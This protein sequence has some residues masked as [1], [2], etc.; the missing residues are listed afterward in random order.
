MVKSRRAASSCPVVGEGDARMA[1]VGL[2]VAAQGGDLEMPAADERRHR[3]VL[4]A[5]RD[6]ADAGALEAPHDRLRRVGGREVDVL[7]VAAEQRIAHAAADEARLAAV[8]RQRIDH[9]AR[10][11]RL[12]PG[13]RSAGGQ[14]A[15]ACAYEPTASAAAG[16]RWP[17][18][19]RPSSSRGG[20]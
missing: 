10:I 3:A 18:T 8:A 16:S 6:G 12:D 1:A 19:M 15:C 4:D 20:T 9:R 11:R 13:Q 17:G 5:G 14:V 2:D 7:H